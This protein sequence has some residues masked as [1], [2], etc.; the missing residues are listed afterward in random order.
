MPESGQSLRYFSDR[1]AEQW[2]PGYLEYCSQPARPITGKDEVR[3]NP[4]IGKLYE[5]TRLETFD[6][7]LR[8]QLPL[9]WRLADASWRRMLLTQPPIHEIFLVLS[10]PV[11]EMRKDAWTLHGGFIHEG[12]IKTLGGLVQSIDDAYKT[13]P[14]SKR[15]R[16]ARGKYI[17]MASDPLW[18]KDGLN[19]PAKVL[20]YSSIFDSL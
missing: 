17:R 8:S 9:G 6:G 2:I 14:R 19:V 7:K 5:V 3:L 18:R 11:S 4:M 20:D 1:F 10:L 13:I 12:E 15:G 16:P